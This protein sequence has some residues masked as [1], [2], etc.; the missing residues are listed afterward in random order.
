MW[1]E[2]LGYWGRP[3]GL[4]EV[5]LLSFP[6]II[7]TASTTILQVTDRLFL[8]RYDQNALAAALPAGALQ[9]TIMS[10]GFGVAMYVNTFVAQYHGAG[11]P[12]R[13]GLAVW[14]GILLGLFATP[15]LMATIPLAP[16]LF[17]LGGHLPEIQKLE[18]QYFQILM[19]GSPAQIVSAAISAFVA[20]SAS[21]ASTDSSRSVNCRG[22]L[23]V[24]LPNNQR[25]AASGKTSCPRY[26]WRMAS[27]VLRGGSV[28][29]A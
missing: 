8:A 3:G 17:A 21:S 13:I 12:R 15:F 14:Q 5:L 27:T 22:S 7:S 25:F 29:R 2:K 20:P 1:G 4:R 26:T 23:D 24:D 11:R 9:W 6:L 19:V 16:R 28:L 18:V 10:F